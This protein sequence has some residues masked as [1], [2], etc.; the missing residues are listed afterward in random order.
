[1]DIT[2][3]IEKFAAATNNDLFDGEWLVEAVDTF[4]TLDMWIDS[5][6]KW[7]ECSPLKRGEIAGF[8]FLAWS[9]TQLHKG[10]PRQPVSVVD[11]G[12]MRVALVGTDLSAL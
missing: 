6:S 1:M 3:N 10:R 2:T 11:F 8:P 12:E 5:S 7:A 4:E 9:K